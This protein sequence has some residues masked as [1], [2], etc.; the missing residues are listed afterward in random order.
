MNIEI[1]IKK[2]ILDVVRDSL[3]AIP[4]ANRKIVFKDAGAIVLAELPFKDLELAVS[5]DYYTFTF[6]TL[7]NTVLR[8]EVLVS[9]T[10]TNFEIEGED[11][12]MVVKVILS[13]TTGSISSN[14]D[15]KVNRVNWV[16]GR[17]VVWNGLSLRVRG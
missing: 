6:G 1:S 14:A 10:V 3:L 2:A 16:A 7:S 11:T 8:G 13:G 12:S 9:G 5:G 15:I 17:T 4:E